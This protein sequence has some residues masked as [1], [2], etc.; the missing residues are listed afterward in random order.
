MNFVEKN[1]LGFFDSSFNKGIA[2]CIIINFCESVIYAV[3]SIFFYILST[4]FLY[5]F[6]LTGYL[7]R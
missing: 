7:Y 2:L 4:T 1:S 5:F 6:P 3:Y